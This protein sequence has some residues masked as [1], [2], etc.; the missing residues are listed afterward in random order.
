MTNP[1]PVTMLNP[2]LVPVGKPV[3]EAI[4]EDVLAALEKNRAHMLLLPDEEHE[5]QLLRTQRQ[6]LLA[7]VR[8]QAG[9]NV[10]MAMYP[11]TPEQE[12]VD[13]SG[14]VLS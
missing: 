1:M 3:L 4:L 6:E 12:L 9:P 5:Y 2:L 7:W 10:N 13:L 8:A 11:V 14:A